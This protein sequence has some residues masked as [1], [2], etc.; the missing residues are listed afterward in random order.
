M[1]IINEDRNYRELKEAIRMVK[2]QRTNTEK[3]NPIEEGKKF[4][5]KKTGIDEVMKHFE[6]NNSLKF[7]I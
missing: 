7:Q 4:F 6:I 1:K 5:L 3:I 2:S